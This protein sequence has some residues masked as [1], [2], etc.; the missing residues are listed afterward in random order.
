MSKTRLRHET[1]KLTGKQRRILYT[2]THPP[3]SCHLCGNPESTLKVE[4]DV[5][6]KKLRNVEGKRLY[7]HI[8]CKVTEIMSGLDKMN[9]GIEEKVEEGETTI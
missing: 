1:N 6:G 8:P 5:D 7:Y 2:L 3:I 4:R 9:D